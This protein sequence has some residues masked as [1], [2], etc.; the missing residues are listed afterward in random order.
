MQT[1]DWSGSSKNNS[2]WSGYT[3]NATEYHF[4][5]TTS[6]DILLMQNGDSFTLQDGTNFLGLM[7]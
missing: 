4:G 2:D 7:T 3:K 5:E 6:D 1:T